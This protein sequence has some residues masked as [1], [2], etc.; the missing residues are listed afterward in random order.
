MK[1][2]I[3]INLFGALYAIDEDAA[4]LLEQ[5]L[6]NMKR[7]FE[8]R[9]GGDEIADDIEHRVAE[10]FCEMKESGV[11]AF[12]IDHVSEIIHRIGNPEELENNEEGAPAGDAAP[13]D[14]TTDDANASIHPF[15]PA[16]SSYG[17]F[18]NRRLYRDGDDKILGGVMSG[19]CRY[20]G[21]GDPTPWRILMIVLSFL[22]L[23]TVSIIY[24][25]AWAFIPV[26]KTAEDRLRMR[27]LEVTPETLNDELMRQTVESKSP[28]AY[29]TDTA[30]SVF[31]TLLHIC[32]FCFK[33]GC[34]ATIA[35]SLVIL[36]GVMAWL[37]KTGTESSENLPSGVFSN[38]SLD[39]FLQGDTV[40]YACTWFACICMFVALSIPLYMLLRSFLNRPGSHEFRTGTKVT[41]CII[42]V[43]ALGMSVGSGFFV[44]SRAKRHFEVLRHLQNRAGGYYMELYDRE[45]LSEDNWKVETYENCNDGGN[46][47]DDC[48]SFFQNYGDYVNFLKFK[49]G[50]KNRPMRVNLTNEQYFPAG[51]YRLE[52][53][54]Y[55]KGYGS[56]V[57]AKSE[58]GSLATTEIPVDDANDKGNMQ[59][60][61][62]DSLLTTGF[63]NDT[64]SQSDW[65]EFVYKRISA[66]S[67]TASPVFHHAGGTIT[68]GVTNIPEVIGLTGTPGGGKRFGVYQ[69][70][71]SPSGTE[72]GAVTKTP[73]ANAEA[74]KAPKKAGA[75]RTKADKARSKADKTPK[76]AAA[77]KAKADSVR[78]R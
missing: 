73:A 39:P 52:V 46:V 48:K 15:G 5:Y 30:R 23:A 1:K 2:N 78:T 32:A 70:L 45:R 76:K 14:G 10:L 68:Y 26:A 36:Y 57:Y 11:Q 38:D 53:I 62:R 22:S 69:I 63:V 12:S 4:D 41:L 33:A 3:T 65:T 42:S 59:Y 49:K 64:I 16:G 25:L 44:A 47:Y 34:L 8:K 72:T 29:K 37:I 58:A 74:N 17:S 6:D 71:I 21:N 27:G 20:F 56:F 67:Y 18:F 60:F 43:M 9:E 28:Q 51:D 40:S 35:M 55:A 54:G 75:A 7:Y 13:A 77:A 31:N 66:W 61:T 24:L 50:D 19:L